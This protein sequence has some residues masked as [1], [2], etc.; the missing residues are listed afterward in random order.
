MHV[1][2]RQLGVHGWPASMKFEQ[3]SP[4]ILN[5]S[6]SVSIV[7]AQNSYSS[8]CAQK[9][10][11]N[12]YPSKKVLQPL[13]TS[14]LLWFSIK[15]NFKFQIQWTVQKNIFFYRRIAFCYLHN[16]RVRWFHEHPSQWIHLFVPVDGWDPGWTG[17]C[18]SHFCWNS[19]ARSAWWSQNH[20]GPLAGR[21]R[22]G[23]TC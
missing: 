3:T 19:Y 2:V 5:I 14:A 17:W 6:V 20:T 16:H 21:Y 4:L 9:D 8:S 23:C 13:K 15:W 12:I 11:R 1:L 7:I 18:P 22:Y 10:V